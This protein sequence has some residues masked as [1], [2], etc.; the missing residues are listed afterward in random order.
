MAAPRPFKL[1]ERNR[2]PHPHWPHRWPRE[3]RYRPRRNGTGRDRTGGHGPAAAQSTGGRGFRS[4]SERP[5]DRTE[6]AGSGAPPDRKAGNTAAR[7]CPGRK[8][9]LGPEPEVFSKPIPR[10]FRLRLLSPFVPLPTAGF[11]W[12]TCRRGV[13]LAVVRRRLSCDMRTCANGSRA[14]NHLSQA[15]G[16]GHAEQRVLRGGTLA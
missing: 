10:T 6:S 8:W 12:R 4:R 9:D 15:R 16:D 11:P 13:T 5:A 14:I 2:K 7:L 1:Q 3:R